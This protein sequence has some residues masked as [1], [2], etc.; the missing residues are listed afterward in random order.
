V[1]SDE[2]CGVAMASGRFVTHGLLQVLSPA[3]VED[4]QE[5]QQP[6]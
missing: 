1:L 4:R 2:I 5:Q 3:A 6:N